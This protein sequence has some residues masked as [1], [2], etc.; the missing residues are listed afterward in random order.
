MGYQQMFILIFL[1]Y[2][3]LRLGKI[4]LYPSWGKKAYGN[5]ILLGSKRTIRFFK[6][7]GTSYLNI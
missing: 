4:L 6:D 5:V 2:H 1:K 3:M 7:K